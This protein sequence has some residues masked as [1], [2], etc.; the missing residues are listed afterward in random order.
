M[1]SLP[2]AWIGFRK[3]RLRQLFAHHASWSQQHHAVALLVEMLV[4]VTAAAL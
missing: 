2:Q 1:E 3:T 4:A